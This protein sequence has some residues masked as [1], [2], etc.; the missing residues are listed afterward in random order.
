MSTLVVVR[1]GQA[2]FFE[3][4][5]DQLS[6][7][8]QRQSTLLGR[9]W[10]RRAIRFDEVY[11]G[12][13]RRHLETARLAGEQY[14][15]SP[16]AWPA[17]QTADEFDEYAAEAVLKQSL[18]ALVERDEAIRELHAAVGAA[19]DRADTLRQFQRMYEVIIGRWAHGA[20]ELPEIEPW[21]DFC[22][23]VEAGL[24]RI[25]GRPGSRRRVAVI[26]SGGPVGVAMQR[27]LGVTPQKTLELAWMVPNAATSEFLYTTD[28]FTLSRFNSVA[29]L[30]DPDLITY[31]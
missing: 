30:D 18:P 11:T 9:H 14:A 31:R 16:I 12:P 1:H 20:L 19:K 17:P 10:A 15:D 29:H 8:G 21:G 28:K 5:Y 13:R 2:S 23:R 7:L 25:V 3:S 4:D 27:A 6:P 24:A 26:T 22:R